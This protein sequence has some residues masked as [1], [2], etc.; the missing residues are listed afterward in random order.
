[1]AE[2]KTTLQLLGGVDIHGLDRQAAN[3]LLG[4]PK[5]VAL[6]SYL[7]IEGVGGR[8]QRRDLLA[9]LFWPELD[10]E[11]ARA[12]LRKAVYAL[13]AALTPEVILSRGDEELRLADDLVSCDVAEFAVDVEAG[14]LARALESYKGDLMP[15]FH[16]AGCGEFD[17][18]LYDT[19]TELRERA[20][21]TAW[22]LARMLGDD[23]AF[24]EARKWAIRAVSYTWSDERTL[25]RALALMARGGDRAGAL[26]LYD[27]FA[28]RLKAD[29]DA[30]PSAETVALV[31]QIRG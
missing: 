31:S 14:R 22:A 18:W 26:R 2:A 12:A 17:R 7:A 16:I 28:S 15:G 3:R 5:H 10:Q 13:R 11:H 24:T 8:W 29:F 6:L 4:Q 27:E 30:S 23:S 25:R 1:M 19:R 20:A 9:A 21:A